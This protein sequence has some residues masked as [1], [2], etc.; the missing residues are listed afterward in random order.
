MSVSSMSFRGLVVER[1]TSIWKVMGS[2]KYNL[3][4]VEFN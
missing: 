4:V 2:F 3:Y 1:A